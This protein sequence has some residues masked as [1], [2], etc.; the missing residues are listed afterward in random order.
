MLTFKLGQNKFTKVVFDARIRKSVLKSGHFGQVFLILYLA[1]HGA[2]NDD[3]WGVIHMW[4][5]SPR[6][7]FLF[8]IYFNTYFYPTP[9]SIKA[10]VFPPKILGKPKI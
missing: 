1:M 2:C 8:T 6:H 5:D 9:Y 10:P 3:M 4:R 7:S